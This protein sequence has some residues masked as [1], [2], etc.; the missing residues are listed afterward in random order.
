MPLLLRSIRSKKRQAA[1]QDLEGITRKEIEKVLAER[2]GPSLRKSFVIITKNWKH[3]PVWRLTKKFKPDSVGVNVAPTG[4]NKKIWIFV[5]KGT[6]SHPIEA[7]KGKSLAFN[8]GGKGS[9]KSKTL[10]NPA[11]TVSGGGKV[12]DGSMVFPKKVNHPGSKARNFTKTIA[13]DIEPSFKREIENAFRR[14]A[15]KV[16]E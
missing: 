3:K 12:V 14:T 10:S 11:R 6:K 2:V 4:K 16:K 7:K 1:I 15:N 13:K 9:Y 5:D 8:W